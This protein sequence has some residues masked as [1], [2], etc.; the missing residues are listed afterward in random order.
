MKKNKIKGHSDQD[1]SFP[2]HLAPQSPQP[3]NIFD[4]LRQ[5]CWQCN[6]PKTSDE[7]AGF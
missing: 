7:R 1:Y 3:S 6:T 5:Y 2:G 4:T